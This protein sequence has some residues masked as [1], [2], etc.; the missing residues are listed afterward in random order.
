MPEAFRDHLGEAL[1]TVQQEVPALAA[2]LAR[3]VGERVIEIQV[4]GTPFWVGVGPLGVE[5][6]A[7]DRGCVAWGKASGQTIDALLNGKTTIEDAVLDGRVQLRGALN[8]LVAL[9]HGLRVFVQCAVRAPGILPI[10]A[11]WRARKR[12]ST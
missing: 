8:D 6:R 11:S 7:D 9:D 4:D 3:A 1:A 5:L 10:L 12:E 2:A